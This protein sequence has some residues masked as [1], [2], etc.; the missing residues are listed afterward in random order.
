MGTFL[1][2]PNFYLMILLD[3]FLVG[4]AYLLAFLL[5]FEGQVP[6]GDWAHFRDTLPYIIPLKLIFFALFGLYRG[7]WRYTSLMD[8]L[9]IVRTTL[10]ASAGLALFILVTYQFRGFPRSIFIL[11]GILTFVLVGGVRAAIRLV[12]TEK[13]KNWKGLFRIFSSRTREESRRPRKRLLIIGAGNSGEKMLREIQ[14]NSRLNYE[15]AGFLD[16][17]PGKKGMRIHGVPVLGSVSRIMQLAYND[18]MDEILIAMPSAP[19]QEMRRI[20]QLCDAT[21]LK[22]RTTPA[23]GE[24]ID[25]KVSIKTVR[26]VSFEDLVVRDEVKLDQEEIAHILRQKRVL[27]TGAGGSVGSE[28]IRQICRFRPLAVGLLEM[29]ELNLYRMEMECRQRFPYVKVYNFLVDIRRREALDRTFREFRPHVVFH[30]AAYKHVPIQERYP[31]EAVY[32]NVIGSRNLVAASL[33]GRVERFVL[34]SSDKAV[35]P[36]NVM[37]AT[38]RLAEMMIEGYNGNSRTRFMAVRFGNVLGSSGSVIPLF[39]DQIARGGPVT[40]THPDMTR[41]F[42]SVSEAAQLILQA[43]AMGKGGEIFILDM[44]KPVRILDMARDLIRLHGYEP[45]VDIPIQYIGLRP[46]EKLHEELITE[47]EGIV[48]TAHKKIMVLRGNQPW[49]PGPLNEQVDDLLS[50]T[51]NYDCPS[52]KKKLQEL[53]P[54]YTPQL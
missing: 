10:I 47:G 53:I 38:K 2:N 36:A 40:V 33:E 1:R 22:C 49:E 14:E 52:I 46:G 31:W 16:D 44:G 50:I 48:N 37:G 8:L 23:L 9:N 35:R 25:G 51:R 18:E 6:Q 13:R 43:G 54:D 24:L 3:A 17:N 32:N 26:E 34:V 21:G 27:V 42:M 12:L 5:R 41:Y 7:M 45:E 19:A 39:Q 30:A 11:D 28:L 4:A 20:V 29:N 15:V